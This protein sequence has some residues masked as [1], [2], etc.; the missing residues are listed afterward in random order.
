MVSRHSLLTLSTWFRY[1]HLIWLLKFNKSTNMVNKYVHLQFER[2]LS[3][4]GSQVAWVLFCKLRAF[5]TF[6]F[7]FCVSLCQSLKLIRG[8]LISFKLISNAFVLNFIKVSQ[9]TILNSSFSRLTPRELK[10]LYEL[11]STYQFLYRCVEHETWNKCMNHFLHAKA[12]PAPT[13]EP[14]WFTNLDSNNDW[15]CSVNSLKVLHTEFSGLITIWQ[16]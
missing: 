12:S 11:I 15:F 2:I 8:P 7:N 4:Q 14:R 9:I 13:Q 6:S 16:F 1:D 3:Y 5:K 10:Q